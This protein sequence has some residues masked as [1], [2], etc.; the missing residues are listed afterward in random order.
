MGGA[1][2]F[3]ESRFPEVT[4]IVTL[5]GDRV[6]TCYRRD[7]AGRWSVSRHGGGFDP[8]GTSSEDRHL[9]RI[10]LCGG[11]REGGAITLARS[12]GESDER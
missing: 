4:H 2:A 8:Y 11:F 10:F 3:C 1:I 5:A 7:L 9:S 12:I 6:D